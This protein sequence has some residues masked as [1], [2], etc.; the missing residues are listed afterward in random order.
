MN[1]SSKEKKLTKNEL[2]RKDQIETS[3]SQYNFIFNSV[4]LL[5]SM[6]FLI[7]GISSY[8]QRNIISFLK[9]NEILFFPQ[10]VTMLFYGTIGMI[11]SVYQILLINWK[12]GEGFNEFNKKTGQV[13]IFRKGFPGKNSEIKLVYPLE[14]ILRII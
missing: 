4:M 12:V 3:N 2:I 11:I 13:T 7:V 14:D 6:G 9:A 5:G 1:E 10:G 8:L